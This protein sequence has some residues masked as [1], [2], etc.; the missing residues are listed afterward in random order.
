MLPTQY[1]ARAYTL[2]AE[3]QPDYKYSLTIDSAAIV[4]VMGTTNQ[5]KKNEIRV[6]KLEEYGTLIVNLITPDTSM[7]VQL[8]NSSDKVVTQQKA[9]ASGVAEFYF[10]RP[11]T[12]YMRC[13]ADKNGNGIWDVGEYD[14]GIQP[15]RVFYFPKP[16][17][18]RAAWDVEQEW[19]IHGIPVMDQKPQ[20]LIKQKAD[21]QKTPR[22]RNKE[23]EEEKKKKN[24]R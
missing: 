19:D 6:R 23:R 8:L 1:N 18:V 22:E 5:K 21:R 20:A 24:S 4:G 15:E 10:L 3:W 2:Y 13:F 7:V 12:Y 9:S 16:M 17:G 14:K 11:D